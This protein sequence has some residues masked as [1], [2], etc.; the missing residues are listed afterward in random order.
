M[1]MRLS[2]G[3]HFGGSSGGDVSGG[4]IE[5]RP[6]EEKAIPTDSQ[7]KEAGKYRIRDLGDIEIHFLLYE[8]SG[9]RCAHE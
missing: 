5:I 3:K 4:L 1:K 6:V 9:I 8:M 7:A 2:Q